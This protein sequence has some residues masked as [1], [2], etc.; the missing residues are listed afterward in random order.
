M[1]TAI[2]GS[3]TESTTKVRAI[4]HQDRIFAAP[5]G[6]LLGVGRFRGRDENGGIASF[7]AV[8][9]LVP[10]AFMSRFDYS[11]PPISSL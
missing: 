10:R 2:Q 7:A 1:S 5:G 11:R 9:M 8:L 3:G 4:H 6:V